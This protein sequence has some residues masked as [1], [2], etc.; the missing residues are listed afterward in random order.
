[1]RLELHVEALILWFATCIPPFICL[2]PLILA[3][4]L[5]RCQALDVVLKS[6]KEGDS[7]L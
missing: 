6:L 1:M 3:V 4:F 5:A 2:N 7:L